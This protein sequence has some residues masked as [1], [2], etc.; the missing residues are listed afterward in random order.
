MQLG[1][2]DR[3]GSLD[4]G[5]DAD[6]VIWDGH[7]LSMFSKAIKTYV[8]G[9]LYFDIE[10]DAERQIAIEAEKAALMQKHGVGEAGG[11]TTTDRIASPSRP[12]E[13]MNR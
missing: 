8:D 13:E 6:V 3:T 2:D 10:L 4:V 1:I 12:G 5:K 7:P 9:Q 11:R